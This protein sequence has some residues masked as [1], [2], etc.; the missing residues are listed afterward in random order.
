MIALDCSNTEG[1]FKSDVELKIDK[2]S[3]V[4]LNGVKSKT[5]WNGSIL[6][7]DKPL[8]MKI[9]NIVGDES[10]VAV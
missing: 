4:I 3:F 7:K 10:V 9:R 5:H 1:V 6:S 2:N 8:R